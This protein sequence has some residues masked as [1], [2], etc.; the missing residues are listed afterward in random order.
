MSKMESLSLGKSP[1]EPLGFA[2]ILDLGP[3][4]LQGRHRKGRWL[5]E[6][7]GGNLLGIAGILL[8]GDAG[9][10]S[11]RGLFILE[12]NLARSGA[13]RRRDGNLLGNQKGWGAKCSRNASSH[14]KPGGG[15][16]A[17]SKN[18]DGNSG[19]I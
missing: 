1:Q 8:G 2:C 5:P 11:G 18:V 13:R 3:L 16:L 10:S 19:G 17:S 4:S 7:E 9:T 12:R 14:Q 6:L 15:R